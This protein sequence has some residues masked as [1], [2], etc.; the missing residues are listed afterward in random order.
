MNVEGHRVHSEEVVL[1]ILLE[2]S[3]WK[4]ERDV[5][6]MYSDFGTAGGSG[7][8]QVQCWFRVV[9]TAGEG[10]FDAHHRKVVEL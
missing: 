7:S 4:Q 10:R 5:H 9:W 1:E 3:K 2:V 6:L 8:L